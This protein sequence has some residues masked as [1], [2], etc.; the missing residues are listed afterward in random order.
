MTHDSLTVDWLIL[1]FNESRKVVDVS[2]DGFGAYSSAS[3]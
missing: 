2:N 3:E 1:A